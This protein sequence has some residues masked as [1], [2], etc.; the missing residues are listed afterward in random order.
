MAKPLIL[1]LQIDEATQSFYEDLRRRFFPRQ[2]NLIPAHLTLFHQLPD[3]DRIYDALRTTAQATVAFQVTEPK[4]RSIG[5]GVAVFFQPEPL[6]TLH[7]NFLSIFQS[8]LISQDRQRFD[9]HIVVQNKVAPETARHTFDE[10]QDLP[11]L[12]PR[13]IGLTL[14]RYVDGPWEHLV[15]LPFACPVPPLADPNILG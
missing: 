15:D 9:P 3:E 11:L 4:L 1:T 14:W 2:R 10:L 6:R 5:R 13:S 7:R 12:E 8:D